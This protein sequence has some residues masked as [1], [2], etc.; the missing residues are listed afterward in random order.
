MSMNPFL[1]EIYGTANAIGSDGTEKLA[2]AALLDEMFRADGINP[3]ALPDSTILKVAGEIFGPN[4]EIEK[5]AAETTGHQEPDGDESDEEKVA[6]A[7]YL[8]RTMAHAYVQELSNIEKQ[9]ASGVLPGEIAVRKGL[10]AIKTHGK[11]L[12]AHIK[13]IKGRYSEASHGIRSLLSGRDIAS[14]TGQPMKGRRLHY[15]K[16]I[17]KDVAPEA[18]G[19]S[20]AGYGAK[21]A[22]EKKAGII[23]I[24]AEK[25]AMEI[26]EAHGL[27]SD[28]VEEKLASAVDARAE[29]IL[30]QYGYTLR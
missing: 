20:A 8:G 22:L 21:K 13:D 12:G 24:L 17:A 18:V 16:E 2:Q 4:N 25:R 1:A 23:D 5:L 11:A 7:D 27:T 29:E 15:L 30:N 3:E 28:P 10:H 26:L 6:M 19:L 14:G 9:A